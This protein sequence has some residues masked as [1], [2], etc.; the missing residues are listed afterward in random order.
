[1]KDPRNT[2]V[3]TLNGYDALMSSVCF[4]HEKQNINMIPKSL[5]ILLI[6]GEDDP[7]G[8]LGKGVKRVHKAYK[9]AG[10]FDLTMKLFPNDRHEILNEVDKADVFKYIYGWIERRIH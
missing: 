7:V 10:I 1:M 9:E 5:P 6:S 3:F 8:D 4:D 2:Y